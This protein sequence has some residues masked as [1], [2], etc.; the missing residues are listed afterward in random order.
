MLHSLQSWW[1]ALTVDRSEQAAFLGLFSLFC[2]YTIFFS[3]GYGFREVLPPLAGIFLVLLYARH[4]EQSNLAAFPEKR[5]LIIFGLFLLFSIVT[6]IDP[7]AS[8][9]HVGR[10]V[11]KQFLVF[12][13]ALECARSEKNVRIIA[14]VLL[15]AGYLQ[16]LCCLHQYCTGHDI[17]HNDTLR[18]GRLTGTMAWYWVGSYLLLA[19]IPACGL[20]KEIRSKF[21]LGTALFVTA[22]LAM[23][24]AFGILFGGARASYLALISTVC[25]VLFL[26][27]NRPVAKRIVLLFLPLFLAVILLFLFGQG[28][29]SLDTIFSD[30]RLTLWGY[31][32]DVWLTEPITGVGAWQYS[33]VVQT[34]PYA[35]SSPAELISL[36]H[37]HNVYLQILCETGLLGFALCFTAIAG[38]LVFCCR[39]IL[40]ARKKDQLAHLAFFFWLA[41]LAFLIHGIVGH[42]FFR[43]WY[44]TLFFSHLGVACGASL[45]IAS[46]TDKEKAAA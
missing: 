32:L 9:L 16:G 20:W 14:W 22:A 1:K 35:A 15:L 12:F 45:H 17:I 18:A 2:F 28:R 8:F 13:L 37:P 34:L 4:Y 36:S 43:P 21:S 41:C 24:I 42:D 31:S 10:G 40:S 23:P 26:N 46:T 6:S 11:N 30:S 27:A 19:A 29:L 44:Q 3:S 33:T 7:W 38:L 25:I 39:R 5:L